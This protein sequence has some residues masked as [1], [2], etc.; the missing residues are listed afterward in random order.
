MSFPGGARQL[1]HIGAGDGAEV[2]AWQAAGV[3]RLLLAE[4]DPDSAR[5]C[6]GATVGPILCRSVQRPEKG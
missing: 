1:L 2:A 5:G 6:D 3:T 4:A